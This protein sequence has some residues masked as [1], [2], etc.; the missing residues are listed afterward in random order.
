MPMNFSDQ[1]EGERRARGAT[2]QWI[3]LTLTRVIDCIL[4]S[5]TTGTSS[6]GTTYRSVTPQIQTTR[7][8]PP[9][10][11]DRSKG[12]EPIVVTSKRTRD[13]GEVEPPRKRHSQGI[14]LSYPLDLHD[15]V[16][17]TA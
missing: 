7:S 16:P 12:K 2:F 10:I 15:E 9:R 11:S 6:K 5:A 17:L 8:P 4:I 14:R 1:P 13:G 3:G